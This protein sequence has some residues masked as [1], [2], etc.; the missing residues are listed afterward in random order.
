MVNILEY[1][2]SFFIPYM[3]RAPS[4]GVNSEGKAES[5][6]PAELSARLLLGW[7]VENGII[8]IILPDRPQRRHAR[9]TTRCA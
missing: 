7:F 6:R 2:F 3:Q 8:E 5:A 4:A 1:C 9:F